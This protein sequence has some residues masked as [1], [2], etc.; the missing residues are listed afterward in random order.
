VQGIPL[1]REKK[2]KKGLDLHFWGGGAAGRKRKKV[3]IKEWGRW[4][5]ETEDRK[6][7]QTKEEG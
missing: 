7:S 2:P 1:I 4:R 6:V 3:L 5:K